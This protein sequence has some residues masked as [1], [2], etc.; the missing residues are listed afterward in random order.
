[1]TPTVAELERAVLEAADA[2][3]DARDSL[4]THIRFSAHMGTV[5]DFHTIWLT[6]LVSTRAHETRSAIRAWRKSKE[7]K[8]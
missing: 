1:M 4:E 5:D 8:P 6:N 2:E 7:Q 3:T